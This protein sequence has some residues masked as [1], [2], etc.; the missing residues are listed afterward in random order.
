MRTSDFGEARGGGGPAPSKD[1]DGRGLAMDRV[2]L[3]GQMLL[4]GEDPDRP[5]PAN[6]TQHPIS[7]SCL[8]AGLSPRSCPRGGIT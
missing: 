6:P 1:K 7:P 2:T 4:E 3:S 8:L 5:L